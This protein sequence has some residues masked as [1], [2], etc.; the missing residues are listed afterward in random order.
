MPHSVLLVRD[1]AVSRSESYRLSRLKGLSPED[2][3]FLFKLIH[4]LLP[5]KER[6]HHL[7]PTTSPLCQCHSGA[8]ATYRHLFFECCKNNQ[9]GEALLRCIQSYDQ[10]LTADKTLTLQLVSDEPFMLASVAILVTGLSLIWENSKLWKN[11]SLFMIRA[12]LEAAVSLRRRS[13]LTRIREA[14]SIMHN[15]IEHFRN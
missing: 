14:G 2:K 11:T 10:S 3:S 4:T 12:D 7:T 5:S 6:L 8:N 1:P 13:R 9:V 15:L